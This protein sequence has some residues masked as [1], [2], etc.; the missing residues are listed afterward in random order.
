LSTESGRTKILPRDQIGQFRFVMRALVNIS[1]SLER[2][3]YEGNRL[4]SIPWD[5]GKKAIMKIEEIRLD[6]VLFSRSIDVKIPISVVDKMGQKLDNLMRD[7]EL[8]RIFSSTKYTPNIAVNP[9]DRKYEKNI[10]RGATT[11]EVIKMLLSVLSDIYSA[12]MNDN[13]AVSEQDLL[14]LNM[15]QVRKTI[16]EQKIGPAQFDIQNGKI[17]VSNPNLY[18]N[19]IDRVAIK[20]A[21]EE[22]CKIG[23]NIIEELKQKNH[24]PKLVQSLIYLQEK[25]INES[26][27][28]VALGMAGITCDVMCGQYE[29]ELSDSMLGMIRAHTRNVDIFAAQFPDWRRFLENAASVDIDGSVVSEVQNRGQHVADALEKEKNIVSP[30]VTA[31]IRSIIGATKRPGVTAKRAAFAFIRSIEN[32][33]IKIYSYSFEFIDKTIKKTIDDMSSIASKA[34]VISLLTLA[35]QNAAQ[36]GPIALRIPEMSWLRNATEFVQNHINT[37]KSK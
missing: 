36:I 17:F 8:G 31:I 23:K 9:T 30:E 19:E 25:L 5:D 21:R 13:D 10:G 11:A 4:G 29:S 2:Q 1:R 27:N 6:G 32:L 33:I 34:I 37:M 3:F 24:D 14:P 18:K 28:V 7:R 12:S 20:A 22:L 35:L 16:P 15:E 26:E